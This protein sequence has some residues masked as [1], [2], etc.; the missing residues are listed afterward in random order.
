[1]SDAPHNY[2]NDPV[3]L[4]FRDIVCRPPKEK[5]CGPTLGLWIRV[6]RYQHLPTETNR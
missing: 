2:L 5:L 6:G 4:I 1:M 3:F